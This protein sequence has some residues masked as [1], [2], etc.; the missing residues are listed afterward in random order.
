MATIDIDIENYID[1]IDDYYLIREL[2]RR[3][4]NKNKKAQ[5]SFKEIINEMIKG[6]EDKIGWPK[7]L[8]VADKQKQ[9]WIIENWDNIKL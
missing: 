9:E 6:E 2:K 4:D 7:I 3:A 1:E 5:E 8:T